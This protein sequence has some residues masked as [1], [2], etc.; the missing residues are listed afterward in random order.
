MFYQHN[1]KII[2]G[3][4]VLIILIIVLACVIAFNGNNGDGW[5]GDD[6]HHHHHDQDSI[7]ASFGD[8]SHQLPSDIGTISECDNHDHHDNH[9][10]SDSGFDNKKKPKGFGRHYHK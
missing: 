3:V 7:L 1:L 8:C 6:D 10:K 5:D 2:I 4:L 9:K